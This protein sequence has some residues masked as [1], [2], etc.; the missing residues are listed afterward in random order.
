MASVHEPTVREFRAPRSMTPTALGVQLAHLVWESFRDLLT[1]AANLRVLGR[2]DML[3][4]DGVP[5]ARAEEEV[6]IFLLWVHTR[7]I[8]RASPETESRSARAALDA[9][10]RTVFED[11]L[12]NGANPGELPIFEERVRTRY[13]RYR[14]A[15]GQSDA[16]VGSAVIEAMTGLPSDNPDD[17]RLFASRGLGVLAPV[18]DFYSA[19]ELLED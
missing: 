3:D 10:H 1:D 19:L 15:A 6:L 14:K 13:E 4:V 18:R 7:A 12:A 16:A 8:Q 2:L 11:M 17:S 9:L 5:G